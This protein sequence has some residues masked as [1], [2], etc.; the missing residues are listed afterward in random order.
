LEGGN[1]GEVYGRFSHHYLTFAQQH[2]HDYDALRPEW[3]NLMAAMQAAHDYELWQTVIDF[4]DA[5]H[6]GWFVRGRYTQ[7]RQGFAWV[8][9]AALAKED[10]A[11]LAICLLHWGEAC[12]EQNDYDASRQLTNQSLQIY[13]ELDDQ[14]GTADACYLMARVA[15]EQNHYQE[16]EHLLDE[17]FWFQEKV[18]NELAKAGIYFRQAR[19]FYETGKYQM[20]KERAKQAYA[21]YQKHNDKQG[22]I[23]TLRYLAK[24][25]LLEK[26]FDEALNHSATA[27]QLIEELQD[28]GELAAML[29]VLVSI[30][31]MMQRY[32]DALKYADEAQTICDLL[33]LLKFKASLFYEKSLILRHLHHYQEALECSEQSIQMFQDLHDE[34]SLAYALTSQGDVYKAIGQKDKSSDSWRKA[35]IIAESRNHAYFLKLLAERESQED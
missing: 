1:Q 16:A 33:G 14:A 8:Y 31:R 13:H 17:S 29:N 27:R 30:Y 25:A 35:K 5:L 20:A 4:A 24:V 11:R 6:D 15:L 2:P 23:P 10:K 19:I 22:M 26:Q 32:E 34:L 12:V 28:R 9:N 7:A 18:G 3:D 21:I